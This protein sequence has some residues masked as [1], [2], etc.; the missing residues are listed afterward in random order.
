MKKNKQ[1]IEDAFGGRKVLT[2]SQPIL[3]NVSE[4]KENTQSSSRNGSQ[5]RILVTSNL[6]SD[7]VKI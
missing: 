7:K 5:Q 1:Q 2:V 6:N 3:E 4:H